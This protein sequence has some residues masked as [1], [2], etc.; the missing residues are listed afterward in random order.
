MKQSDFCSGKVSA[1][2]AMALC[3]FPPFSSAAESTG[4]TYQFNDGFIVGSREKVDLSR[5]STSAIEEGVYS[6]D[7]YTNG[8]WKG[9]YDLHVT[10]QKDGTLGI[11]YTRAMLAKYGIAAE[12]LNTALSEKEGFCGPLKAW[13]DEQNVQDN[14][15]Q[16]SLRLEI[17]VPQIYE[18]QRLKNYVSPEFW[19]KG[20]AALNLG[21]M[22][23]AWNNHSSGEGGSDNNSAYLGLNGGLSWNGWLL[24]H[25]GNLNWQEQQGGAHWHSN[26]TYLQRP[27]PQM[28]SIF[29]GGQLFT[30]GE[31]FDT[32]GVRGLNMATDDN[33]F[34]DGM[35][36]Y[37]PEIRGVAQSNALVT[38]R[39]GSNIIYQTTVPPGPFTLKDVYPSGYGSDLDVSVKE[40]DGTVNVFSVPYASVAQLVR[41]GMTRYAVSA[42]KVDDDSLRHKPMLYQATWQH[43]L[44]NMFTGYTGVTGFNDYQALLLGTG[45]NTGI[46]ALS[47]DVTHSRLKSGAL[48]ENGQSYRATFNRM[49][50][51]TQ[52]SIVLAAY[53]YSTKGYYNLNDALYAVD[54]ERNSRN[55]YTLWRQ[56]NGMTF[57]VNQNLPE[58]W[59][60]FYL[61]GRVSDYWNR[62]GTEK[63]YQLSY[64]N[65]FGRLSWSMS[66]Q[67]V[68]TPD[69]SGHR[70]DDRVSFNFSYPLW[71]GE[72]RTANLTSNTAFNNSHFANSQVGI[73]GSLDSENNLNYGVSTSTYSGGKHDVALNGSYRTPWTTM[74]GSY[75]QGS[76]YRQSGIGGSGT[77][78]AH[79]GGV[80]MS[81]ETGTTMALIE[82]K[83]AKGAMLP[84]SPGTRVDSNGYAILP[85]LRPYRIN[86]VEIDPKGS[87]DDVAFDRTVAQVVPWEG[88]VVKVTFGTTVQNNIT[89]RAQ[90]ASGQ[91]LPFAATIYDPA[92]KEIGVVGQGSMMFI[93]S[94]GA[95][96]AIVK[97]TGG[98]CAV[99]L[100]ASNSKEAV[101]R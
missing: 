89:L 47:F 26:Q 65:S 37:A 99:D 3:S 7:V 80:V 49:F 29:T 55:N 87:Q 20:I 60:G 92:G 39:Q 81:P 64:N 33:M 36:S 52:T 30:S 56:K 84:G 21:W 11:C 85:Y 40:A 32:I 23:N 8:E 101:C 58:G 16:S 50:V 67:R 15:I 34:P 24:K 38:V 78:I 18:D 53:R 96:R 51:E 66:A 70:K 4:S 44:S 100:N 22:A 42:G 54:Q 93:S 6:L 46:G 61:S 1:A 88:S 10:R 25:I 19:D 83:D 76:G 68:Y 17:S 86:A 97:W 73:N 72:N 62:S 69:S 59:G 48:D 28:N 43:G 14:L 35:R 41:P 94:A 75:S 82:A 98:Q 77:L 57:T 2:L 9:R 5:F 95:K 90:Q 74:T 13:R 27:I 12:K 31:F 79:R 71:F 45:M 63:Q 91:P